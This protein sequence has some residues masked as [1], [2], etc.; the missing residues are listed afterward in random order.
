MSYQ[1]QCSANR[2]VNRSCPASILA[3]RAAAG[4]SSGGRA[5]DIC[6][7]A[8]AG[9][10]VQLRRRRWRSAS[11]PSRVHAA[12]QTAH[13]KRLAKRLGRK[14]SAAAAVCA[15]PVESSESSAPGGT[16]L[17]TIATLTAAGTS[18]AACPVGPG[19]QVPLCSFCVEDLKRASAPS[20]TPAGSASS[21]HRACWVARTPDAARADR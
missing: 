16:Q 1:G 7:A 19:L 14:G 5:C 2:S 6:R 10:S 13:A 15:R 4:S 18:A 9:S 11:A 20:P 12:R 3:A 8:A 21:H 17:V